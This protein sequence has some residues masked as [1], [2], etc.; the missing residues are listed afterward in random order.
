MREKL[1]VKDAAQRLGVSRS[2]VYKLVA[3]GELEVYRP[4]PRK[5]W[6]WADAIEDY[7]AAHTTKAAQPPLPAA[8]APSP[9]P[10]P[11]AKPSFTGVN[12]PLPL[13]RR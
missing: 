3:R 9:T 2:G 13:G 4:T 7:I 10:R 12:F 8:E 1:T 5:I 6:V 11:R